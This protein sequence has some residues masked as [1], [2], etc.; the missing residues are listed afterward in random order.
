[1]WWDVWFACRDS[2]KERKW[3][4]LGTYRLPKYFTLTNTWPIW[5]S[6]EKRR[7]VTGWKIQER[8][9]LLNKLQHAL[10][11]PGNTKCS[12]IWYTR[13]ENPQVKMQNKKRSTKYPYTQA[14]PN[15]QVI[16]LIIHRDWAYT[17]YIYKHLFSPAQITIWR[18]SQNRW[19]PLNWDSYVLS[20]NGT[21]TVIDKNAL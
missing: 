17:N 16:T 11:R 9:N 18:E 15:N 21:A 7:P 4:V 8:M 20:L 1:M 2:P 10:E 19:K 3:V 5:F 6:L 14:Y 12:A 13:L